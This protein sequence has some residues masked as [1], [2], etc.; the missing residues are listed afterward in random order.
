[1]QIFT[2]THGALFLVL[3][4]KTR[5]L[6][7]L[8]AGHFARHCPCT[9]LVFCPASQHH[10]LSG[11]NCE[12]L[13]C[14]YRRS[15]LIRERKSLPC[16]AEA[17]L[18]PAFIWTCPL[19]PRDIKDFL[20]AMEAPWPVLKGNNGFPIFW[21]LGSRGAC[22]PGESGSDRFCYKGLVVFCVTAFD[23]NS[24]WVHP[25]IHCNERGYQL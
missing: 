23:R 24:G 20:H 25:D 11:N 6:F 10:L 19:N 15:P 18:P 4:H 3:S 14:S 2:F 12:S 13:F 21:D 9:A 7:V 22:L 8:G 16:L 17:A 5:C 1:M